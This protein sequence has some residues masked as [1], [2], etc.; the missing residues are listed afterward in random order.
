MFVCNVR[1]HV[2]ASGVTTRQSLVSVANE[3][4]VLL[5]LVV[6]FLYTPYNRNK[7]LNLKDLLSS[8]SSF[9]RRA[10]SAWNPR[11]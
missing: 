2:S 6:F 5:Q 1:E 10:E 11:T 3:L 7:G 8:N 9:F 4:I